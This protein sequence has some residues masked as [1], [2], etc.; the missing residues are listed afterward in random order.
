M[1]GGVE[2]P[3][4][5]ADEPAPETPT[6]TATPDTPAAGTQA[7]AGQQAGGIPPPGAAGGVG[8][9]DELAKRLYERIRGRLRAELRLDRERAGLVTDLRR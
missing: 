8:D 6:T 1:N 9:L 2:V 7:P 5:R 4:Q 3:V